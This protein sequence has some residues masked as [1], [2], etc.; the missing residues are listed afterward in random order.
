M[1]LKAL[2]VVVNSLAALNAANPVLMAITRQVILKHSDMKADYLMGK[3]IV[4]IDP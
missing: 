2:A 4:D 1:D 3:A